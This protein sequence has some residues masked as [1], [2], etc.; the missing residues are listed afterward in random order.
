MKF[1]CCLSDQ[2]VQESLQLLIIISLDY[3]KRSKKAL[4]VL[5]FFLVLG[6]VLVFY[7]FIFRY[8]P[9]NINFSSRTSAGQTQDII[10]SKLDR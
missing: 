2:L 6:F 4:C 10:M 7:C 8:I 9:I 5:V 3:L 1:L